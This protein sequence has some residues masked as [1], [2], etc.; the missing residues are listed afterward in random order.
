M[1]K[2]RIVAILAGYSPPLAPSQIGQIAEEIAKISTAEIKAVA[3]AKAVAK[4]KRKS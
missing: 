3:K 4:P 2:N 1:D